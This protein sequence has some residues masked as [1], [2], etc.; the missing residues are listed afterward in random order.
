MP[1]QFFAP[2]LDPEFLARFGFAVVF[3]WVWGIFSKGIFE[4]IQSYIGK[5]IYVLFRQKSGKLRDRVL[6]ACDRLDDL[7]AD[8]LFRNSPDIDQIL[9]FD[10]LSESDREKLKAEILK[11]WDLGI[12]LEKANTDPIP[13]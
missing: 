3:Y 7:L 9:D 4:P 12:A 6:K 2:I 5:K 10:D 13:F 11:T 8:A 1:N